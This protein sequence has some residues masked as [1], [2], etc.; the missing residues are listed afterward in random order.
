VL[1]HASAQE[2]DEHGEDYIVDGEEEAP[3]E[4]PWQA[5]TIYTYEKIILIKCF[6]SFAK[7]PCIFFLSRKFLK[8]KP[9]ERFSLGRDLS[10]W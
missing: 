8:N 10:G 2:E 7:I 4:T 9:S 5:C 1:G 6:H 3:G